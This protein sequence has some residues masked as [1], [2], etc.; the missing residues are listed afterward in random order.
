[1][2]T[3]T[4][5]DRV[6]LG[7]REPLAAHIMQHLD[8]IDVVEV[9]AEPYFDASKKKRQALAFLARTVPVWLHGVSMG[10]ASASPV[11]PSTVYQMAKLMEQVQ[12]E[13]W[14]EHL[15]FVRANG[16][17]IH[18]LCAP[19]RNPQTL[20]STLNN[21]Q[22]AAHRVGTWPALENIASLVQ[23]PA[24]P[25]TEAQWLQAIFNASPAPLL[26]DLHN[27]YANSVN[28]GLDPVAQLA[29]WPL[30]R[31]TCIHL[32]GGQW[33][34]RPDGSG[35]RWLD[36]HEHDVPHEVFN[37]L[38][39]VAQRVPQALTVIIERDGQYPA[40]NQLLEQVQQARMALSAGRSLQ[41]GGNELC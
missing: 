8:A 25:F 34:A 31:V 26:L 22:W 30:H 1:M 16:R 10:L 15:A 9:I 3:K 24:S 21:I 7:W 12:P 19:A 23:P 20:A 28:A 11:L 39:V 27:L 2:T 37:L 38:S 36:D 29:Q 33:I 14:S 4:L 41:G 18:H 40:F 13:A 35:K 6:G 32:S 17:E 5:P